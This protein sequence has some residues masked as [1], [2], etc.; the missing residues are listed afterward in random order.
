M[1]LMLPPWLET[2]RGEIEQILP[3]VRLPAQL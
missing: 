1:K 2:H 3:P